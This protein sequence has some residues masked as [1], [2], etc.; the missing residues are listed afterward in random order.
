MQQICI[1]SALHC[2]VAALTLPISLSLPSSRS[3]PLSIPTVFL[4][5]FTCPG[6]KDIVNQLR[7]LLQLHHQTL[8]L[9]FWGA[10]YLLLLFCLLLFYALLLHMA[11]WLW[12]LLLYWL[13]DC[14]LK[15]HVVCLSDHFH[16]VVACQQLLLPC[17]KS[18]L[19]SSCLPKI[20][21]IPYTHTP[22][23]THSNTHTRYA[24]VPQCQRHL[25]IY[26][27]F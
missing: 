12:L 26:C 24:M 1:S 14:Q 3:V 4:S 5:L 7:C 10:C 23:Y 16:P 6:P 25:L 21:L 18:K 20:S 9:L 17:S 15:W 2:I 22:L 13:L 11:P 19:L 27:H 8:L